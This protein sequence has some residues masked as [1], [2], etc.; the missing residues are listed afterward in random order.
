MPYMEK[1]AATAALAL[2]IIG[3]TSTPCFQADHGAR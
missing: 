3:V 1:S 2:S